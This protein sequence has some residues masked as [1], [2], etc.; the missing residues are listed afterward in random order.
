[1]I[2]EVGA[3]QPFQNVF[4][5]LSQWKGQRTVCAAGRAGH[6]SAS[7]PRNGACIFLYVRSIRNG[8][9]MF[10]VCFW[11]GFEVAF[12]FRGFQR[13]FCV[14]R[15][16][17]TSARKLAAARPE[18]R[19]SCSVAHAFS[20]CSCSAA[21]CSPSGLRGEREQPCAST[22]TRWSVRCTCASVAAVRG[23]LV[24]EGDGS[25]APRLS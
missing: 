17:L 1:M 21:Q 12:G 16:G 10:C 9:C 3:P 25:Y 20:T 23:R 24:G 7:R 11:L 6:I 15:L 5:M 8:A 18:S 2:S 22:Q 4:I 19:S 14:L 13:C